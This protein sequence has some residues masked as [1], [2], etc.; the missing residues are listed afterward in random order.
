MSVSL[1]D[2][3]AAT[4]NELSKSERRVA[5]AVLDKPNLVTTENIAQLARRARVSEPTVF[6]FCRRF[7]ARGFPDFK[8][9]LSAA[10]VK[11][12]MQHG[13]G[14]RAGD[15][16]EDVAARV[17]ES[18][19]AKINAAERSLNAEVLARS[20]DLIS[21]SRR[22]LVLAQ[23]LSR[24]AAEDFRSRLI[25]LGIACEFY[26]DRALMFSA[27]ASLRSGELVCA[28]SLTGENA[29]VAAALQIARDAGAAGIAVA[30]ENSTIAS[31]CG[32]CLHCGLQEPAAS[33]DELMTGRVVLQAM[34]QVIIAGVMLRRAESIKVLK[35][36]LQQ[37]C[38]GIYLSR[39][40]ADAQQDKKKAE[41]RTED[42]AL[43]PGEPI[44]T[45]NWG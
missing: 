40:A 37:A 22:T 7:G 5:T 35:P 10:F 39:D 41:P 24:A 38:K 36:R 8:L 30:P 26:A 28:V 9:A 23:G 13:G 45:L 44:T 32:L 15:S 3:I 21:Q 29:D 18:I 19:S 11:E 14:V 27:C 25:S 12:P 33:D 20:I 2:R 6:R 43:K 16:V 34:L 31:R 4:L 42:V 1:L 17:L